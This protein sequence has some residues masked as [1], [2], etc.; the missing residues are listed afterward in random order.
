MKVCHV[1]TRLIVGGAQENTVATCIG[2]RKLGYDCDLVIGP[3]T[4]PEGSLYEQARA[5][6][7]PISIVD[8]LRRSPNPFLDFAAGRA[9]RRLFEANR[10]DIVHTHSGKAGFVGRWAA[11]QARVPVVVAYDSRA[12]VLPVPESGRELDFPVGGTDCRR[13]DDTVCFRGGCDERAVSG[14]RDSREVCDD[15]QRHEH[16][17]VLAGRTAARPR[18]RKVARLFRLKGHEYLFEAVPRIVAAVPNVKFLIVGE[19][20]YRE[21][22][23]RWAETAGIARTFIFT[24][25]VRP[26]EIPG[27][28]AQMDVL[29]HLSLREGL[30]RTSMPYDR[31][32]AR[33]RLLATSAATLRA[34]TGARAHPSAPYTPVSH[35]VAPVR[36]DETFAQSQAFPPSARTARRYNPSPTI[37]ISRSAP[38]QQSA[39]PPSNKYSC[40]FNRNNRATLP[41]T[42]S[43]RGSAR[44]NGS[45]FMPL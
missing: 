34:A 33:Q 6:G 26:D 5:A 4:G 19:G 18:R 13:V 35:P 45:M 15:S 27:Y 23:E 31:H 11:R 21:R 2:L 28:M 41:T 38:P 37:E 22:Y 36:E 3:Q 40:P 9:L 44:K 17:A 30:P 39:A 10:Y 12:I 14:G 42:R 25:L 29:V 7:V 24:G 8:E 20:L 1:I 32:P 16:R 43:C